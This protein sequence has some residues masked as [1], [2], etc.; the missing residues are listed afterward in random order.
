[1]DDFLR[2]MTERSDEL[3]SDVFDI[4]M[5]LSDFQEFVDLMASFRDEKLG[6]GL[7]A[8]LSTALEVVNLQPQASAGTDASASDSKSMSAEAHK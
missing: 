3:H 1:M 8:G 6:I 4:L 2:L 5:T 7:T